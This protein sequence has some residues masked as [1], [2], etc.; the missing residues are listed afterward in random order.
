MEQPRSGSLWKTQGGKAGVGRD[1][2]Q[3]QTK[4]YQKKGF[5]R[6]VKLLSIRFP[7]TCQK[8]PLRDAESN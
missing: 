6:G 7:L 8:R 1:M 4:A 5:P 2:G 3:V